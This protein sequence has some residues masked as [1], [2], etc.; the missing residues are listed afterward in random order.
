MSEIPP[1]QIHLESQRPSDVAKINS[2]LAASRKRFRFWSTNKQESR[3][4]PQVPLTPV[5][6]DLEDESEDEQR[7]RDRIITQL[8][9]VGT[10]G[11]GGTRETEEWPRI[12][13]TDERSD[14]VDETMGKDLFQWAVLYENQ[15][16]YAFSSASL[17]RM[18]CDSEDTY[19]R[20]T[21]FGLAWYSAR[22]LLPYDPPAF[23]IPLERGNT[24]PKSM[25]TPHTL[26]DFQ[27]PDATWL[28][29]SRSWLVQMAG[30]GGSHDG[31]EYNW[32]FRKK[33]YLLH[34]SVIA[35][36]R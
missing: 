35:V 5:G 30:N 9:R 21:L 7:L 2:H 23:T 28:W 18:L 13:L 19:F 17:W 22:G 6:S 32:C 24:N 27:L 12:L 8:K 3:A 4:Y 10:S 26:R 31:F 34:F 36:D 20:I 16:G 29:V 15:R 1:H 11:A 33:G 14:V 25:I